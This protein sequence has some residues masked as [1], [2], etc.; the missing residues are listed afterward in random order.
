MVRGAEE[1]RFVSEKGR[2]LPFFP[3]FIGYK[4]SS[5]LL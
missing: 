4:S 5:F 2:F 3:L 1:G